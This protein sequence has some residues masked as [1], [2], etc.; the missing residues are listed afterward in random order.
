LGLPKIVMTVI[1]VREE[2]IAWYKRNGYV[3][4][5]AREPFPASDVHIPISNQPLE[6]IVLEKRIG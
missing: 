3:D 1:S 5:G 2:L 6:F 4:T